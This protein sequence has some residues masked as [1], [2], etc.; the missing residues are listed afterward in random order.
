MNGGN[1]LV[2]LREVYSSEKTLLCNTLLKEEISSWDKD[3]STQPLSEELYEQLK[4]QLDLQSS[5]VADVSLTDDSEEVAVYIA[6]YVCKQLNCK[7]K[8]EKCF[9]MRL[10]ESDAAES[11]SSKYMQLLSR[12]DFVKPP[13]DVTQ[14]V[15]CGFAVLDFVHE[16]L[17]HHFSH[18]PVKA[19]APYALAYA[20]PIVSF[21]C[22]EHVDITSKLV[23][24]IITLVN[25]KV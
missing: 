15:C 11:R 20:G 4:I 23:D 18:I 17:L 5:D 24:S 16:M 12:G 10:V 21:S 25:K 1:F 13:N 6:G 14:Y 22:P 3:L 2:S 7:V 19:A 9:N 8:C